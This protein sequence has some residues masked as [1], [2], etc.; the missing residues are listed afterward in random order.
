M[1]HETYFAI[2]APLFLGDSA[3]GTTRHASGALEPILLRVEN[4]LRALYQHQFT[5]FL[6]SQFGSGMSFTVHTNWI[7]LQF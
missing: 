7:T 3:I 2:V 5:R 1:K 4:D 6:S